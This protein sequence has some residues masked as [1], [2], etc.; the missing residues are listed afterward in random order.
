MK[1]P[2]ILSDLDDIKF[3]EHR[4]RSSPLENNIMFESCIIKSFRENSNIVDIILRNG[5]VIED[6]R[7]I[8]PIKLILMYLGPVSDIKNIPAVLFYRFS[9]EDGFV[10]IGDISAYE[11]SDE[12]KDVNRPF[13]V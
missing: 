12:E 6:V 11:I 9:P 2:V 4:D 3:G 8:T 5:N 10:M 13:Y 1:V 7:V